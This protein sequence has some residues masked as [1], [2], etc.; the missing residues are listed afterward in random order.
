M[1]N[2]FFDDGKL[3]FDG[4]WGLYIFNGKY[5]EL[6]SADGS[7]TFKEIPT[8]E[9]NERERMARELAAKLKEGVDAEKILVESFMTCFDKAG[10]KKLH[11]A[12]MKSKRKLN[13]KTREHRCV[14]LKVGN[15][16]VP[17]MG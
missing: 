1:D 15:F 17:I 2:K 16:I 11:T 6:S 8:K 14:D 12:V 5:Y 7:P 13:V 10:L 9:I 4:K 3:K